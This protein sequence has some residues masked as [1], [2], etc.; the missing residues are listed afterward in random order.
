MYK[1]ILNHQYI[2]KYNIMI[3]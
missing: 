3:R 1:K 2:A